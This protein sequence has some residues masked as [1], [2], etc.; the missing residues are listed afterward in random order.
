MK[1]HLCEFFSNL[2]GKLKA[3]LG[4]NLMIYHM[5][6]ALIALLILEKAPPEL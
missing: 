4:E 1:R 5:A 6:W 2:V 3:R